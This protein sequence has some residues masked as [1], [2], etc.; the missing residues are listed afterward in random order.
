VV[1]D[2]LSFVD[3]KE[4]ELLSAACNLIVI[5]GA[6][7]IYESIADRLNDME[8]FRTETEHSDGLIMKNFLF[9]FVNNYFVLFYIAYARHIK[10][11][12]TPGKSCPQSCLEE[13]QIQM[14]VVFTAKTFGLQAV[15]L[16]KPFVQKQIKV[17]L[18]MK[19]MKAIMNATEDSINKASAIAAETANK[20]AS[21]ALS[22]RHVPT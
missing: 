9:Q 1:Y 7:F 14:L 20:T 18:E 13:I 8:N 16:A 17:V 5:Q 3:R 4:L 15:E 19:H 2:S 10:V 12:N 22:V 21:F 6:G 11:G